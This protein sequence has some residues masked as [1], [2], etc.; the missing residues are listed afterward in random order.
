[1]AFLAVLDVHDV[2]E[3]G[4]ESRGQEVET[5]CNK[6]RLYTVKNAYVEVSRYL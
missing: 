5:A 1:M 6:C 3:D 2:V 4:V